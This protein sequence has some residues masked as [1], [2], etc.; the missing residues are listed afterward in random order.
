MAEVREKSWLNVPPQA[1]TADGFADGRI[2]I[3]D[4]SGFFVKQRVFVVS[5]TQP[6][7]ELE[8]KFVSDEANIYVGPLDAK[9][10]G[11][12]DLTAYTMADNATVSAPPQQK[13]I[14]ISDEVIKA[15]YQQ[16][17][18]VALRSALVDKYGRSI[19]STLDSNGLRRLAVDCSLTLAG[20]LTVELDAL[21][22]P[23]QANPDNV[24]IAGSQDGTKSGT[25]GAIRVN[26]DNRLEVVALPGGVNVPFDAIA[27]SYPTPETELYEYFVGG[28]SGALVRSIT[29]TYT[30]STK[31]TLV[32]VEYA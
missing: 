2:Q 20:G 17:P 1:F 23:T 9:L 3:D 30:D 31:N 13:S 4:T 10:G 8:I 7:I 5:D 25:K 18:A 22:P 16:E 32:S 29:V 11:R 19:D 27:T 15:V 6:K 21:S 14:P 26:T 12:Y 28:L 24:L